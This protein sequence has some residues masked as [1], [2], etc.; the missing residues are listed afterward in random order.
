M[1]WKEC[2]R[3]YLMP[4]QQHLLSLFLQRQSQLG[5]L[6]QSQCVTWES[7][8]SHKHSA[9]EM[10]M[11]DPKDRQS[12]SNHMMSCVL[13]ALVFLVLSSCQAR[14]DWEIRK[15]WFKCLATAHLICPQFHCQSPLDSLSGWSGCLYLASAL[16]VLEES[17]RSEKRSIPSVTD[18]LLVRAMSKSPLLDSDFD[19][20]FVGQ[21]V[22]KTAVGQV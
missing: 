20:N 17:K 13:T 9:H 4:E 5:H 21:R 8:N 3:N 1:S 14:R 18:R 10:N 19:Q 12:L 22:T 2:L 16:R 6:I 15:A 7:L 11:L